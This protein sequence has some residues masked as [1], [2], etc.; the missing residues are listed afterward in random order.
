MLYLVVVALIALLFVWPAWR[1]FRREEEEAR[2]LL[3]A[4]VD[5]GQRDPVTI[6]PWVD[7]AKC[8][9]SGSCVACGGSGDPEEPVEDED[10]ACG[11]V[12]PP[13]STA[14]RTPDAIT[15]AR[16]VVFTCVHSCPPR[17]ENPGAARSYG[18]AWKASTRWVRRMSARVAA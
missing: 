6:A 14:L 13:A 8:M 18:P 3:Q 15:T 5:S 17:A 12:H 16:T 7:P 11:D 2:H 4:A 1:N 10:P 9:G